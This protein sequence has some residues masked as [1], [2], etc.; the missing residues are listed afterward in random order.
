MPRAGGPVRDQGRAVRLVLRRLGLAA[1]SL[2]AWLCASC[3]PAREPDATVVDVVV[4][5]A[6]AG[7][8]TA[9]AVALT[10]VAADPTAG[11]NVMNEDNPR[12]VLQPPPLPFSNAPSLPFPNASSLPPQTAVSVTAANLGM[13]SPVFG[14]VAGSHTAGST[15]ESAPLCNSKRATRC[16]CRSP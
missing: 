3:S 6:P 14:T 11:A 1:A 13:L 9:S 8:S 4:S 2:I 10:T 16:T 5:A 15:G 12:R 7:V